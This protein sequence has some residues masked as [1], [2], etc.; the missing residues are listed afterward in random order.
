[1]PRTQKNSGLSQAYGVASHSTSNK[2]KSRRRRVV[3]KSSRIRN[4]RRI[5]ASPTP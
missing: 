1:M 3:R 2:L 4:G 5:A